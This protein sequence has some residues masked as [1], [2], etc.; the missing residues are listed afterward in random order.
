[1]PLLLVDPQY[2]REQMKTEPSEVLLAT[3]IEVFQV[4]HEEEFLDGPTTPQVA[5]HNFEAESDVL[6]PGT[7]FLS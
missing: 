7:K 3:P 4:L 2:L 5:V 1:M 6:R